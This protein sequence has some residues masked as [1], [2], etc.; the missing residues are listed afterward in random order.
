MIENLINLLFTKFELS[1]NFD[2]SYWVNCVDYFAINFNKKLASYSELTSIA[3]IV[4]K[5]QGP[6]W[7]Y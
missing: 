7:D 3:K 1:L 6:T 5:T 2:N 4:D